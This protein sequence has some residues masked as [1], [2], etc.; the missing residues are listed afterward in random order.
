MRK[1]ILALV[2]ASSILAACNSEKKTSVEADSSVAMTADTTMAKAAEAFS[3]GCYAYTKNRDTA[4]L[5]L[6]VAGEEVT[7]D[8]SYSLYEKDSNKGT[9]AGEIKGDTIIA[10]Y[11]F[12]SEGVR[13]IRE[14]VFLKKGGKL[15]EGF[16]EVETKGMKAIFKDRASLKFEGSIV[17]DPEACK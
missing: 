9:I 14:I 13:S 15:Y 16:G 6:K 17:F 10:E 1:L 7:G 12:N 5:T 3:D 4:L 11:D 2:A 8:L